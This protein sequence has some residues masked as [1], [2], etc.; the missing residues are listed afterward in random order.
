MS[1]A[2]SSGVPSRPMGWARPKSRRAVGSSSKAV[3]VISVSGSCGASGGGVSGPAVEQGDEGAG[4][5]SGVVEGGHVPG[6]GEHV[7]LA[8]GQQLGG[9][10]AH[11]ERDLAVVGAVDQSDGQADARQ[12]PA[13]VVELCRAQRVVD[14]PAG[15]QQQLERPRPQRGATTG[16]EPALDHCRE[17]VG[18]PPGEAVGPRREHVGVQAVGEVVL[19]CVHEHRPA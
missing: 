1:A 18:A 9:R 12:L 2:T 7:E 13:Q 17:H 10:A 16:T 6:I 11:G 3:R 5:R 8:A 19:G 4:E 14:E 15:P